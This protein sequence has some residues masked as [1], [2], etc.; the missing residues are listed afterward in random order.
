MEASC[1]QIEP[2]GKAQWRFKEHWTVIFSTAVI[3]GQIVLEKFCGRISIENNRIAE[4]ITLYHK[5][6]E[7]KSALENGLK[8]MKMRSVAG[9]SPDL[10]RA[11]KRERKEG[12]EIFIH[13]SWAALASSLQG[14]GRQERRR[15]RGQRIEER[16]DDRGTERKT[17][18]C[19]LW[20][21]KFTPT[22]KGKLLWMTS[23]YGP[24]VV[25]CVTEIPFHVFIW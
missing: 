21:C 18:K 24:T 9:I 1:I 4:A 17:R 23:H 15:R 3:E 13:H 6:K 5:P 14:E 25:R 12:R 22:P 11:Y 20:R 19:T 10:M 2:R 16:S 8:H 7:N